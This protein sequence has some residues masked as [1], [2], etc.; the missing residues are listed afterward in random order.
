MGMD[1]L[2][3]AIVGATGAVGREMV[4]L[5][6]D[7]ALPVAKLRPLAS[8]RSA[9]QSIRFAG[10]GV[11]VEVV[12]KH[13]FDNVDIALFAAPPSISQTYAPA[14]V[15][16]GAFVVDSTGA[17]RSRHDVPLVVP[18]VNAHAVEQHHKLVA[19]PGASA[20]VLALALEPLRR[21]AKISRVVVCTYQSAS[22]AG[23]AGM[24]ELR[25][26]TI[27]LLNFKQPP[28]ERF[29]RRL[30]FDSLPQIGQPCSD[31]YTTAEQAMMV[32]LRALL[33]QPT[34]RISCTCVRVPMF[35]G[36]A[37]AVNVEM[38]PPFE[39]EAILSGLQAFP[40]LVHP[41]DDPCP[42][43]ADAAGQDDIFVG[44]VRRDPSVEHGLDMWVVA[45]NLRRGAAAN[46]VQIAQLFVERARHAG[47]G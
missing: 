17:F 25:D 16:A 29:P 11:R 31:G 10:G 13:A 20:T 5:L 38:E 32:E 28:V 18:P 4:A 36:D 3:V 33:E 24:D 37:M 43:V 47:R 27:A 8:E 41:H 39:L 22:G 14:A 1:G 34:L 7:H 45:D 35:V 19:S 21:V 12:D 23:Q 40:G 42:T 15:S 9:G 30:A 26:Q 46:A 6:D 44:R 2:V